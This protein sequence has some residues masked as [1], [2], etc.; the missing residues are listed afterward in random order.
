MPVN[1]YFWS[2]EPRCQFLRAQFKLF[3]IFEARS[4]NRFPISTRA[5]QNSIKPIKFFVLEEENR[6][7]LGGGGINSEKMMKPKMLWCGFSLVVV[8]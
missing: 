5:V 8:V 7:F 4:S 1:F 3:F 6:V 2:L